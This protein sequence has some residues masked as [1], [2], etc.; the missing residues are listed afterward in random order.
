MALRP[1]QV[2]IILG[3]FAPGIRQG[4]VSMGRGNGKTALAAMLACFGLFEGT[5]GAQVLTVASDERQARHVWNAARRMI[6]LNDELSAQVQVFQD[7]IYAPHTDSILAPLPAEPDALQG[8]D[9]TF[10][11]VDELH[12]VNEPTYDAMNLASGKRAQSLVLAISTAAGDKD[13]VMY[14][15]TEHGR[16]ADDPAFYFVEFAAPDGCALDDEGAWGDANPALGDFLSIDA[17]RATLRTTREDVFR[18]YRLNQWVGTVGSWLPWGLWD[19]R[20]TER[21]VSHDERVALFFDGSASGDSTALVGCTLDGFVFLVDLWE[22]P[23]DRGWRVPRAQVDRTIDECFDRYDVV[24][25]ACDPWGWRSEIEAWA[26]RHKRVIEWPTNIVTR[27]APATDRFYA[28]VVDGDV[29]H[30]GDARMSA[31]MGH[32]IAD[33]TTHGDVIRK[34]RRTSPRKI[35]AAVGAIGAY[36]RAMFHAQKPTRKVYVV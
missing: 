25:L 34:D 30:D 35:D 19:S 29:S 14:R 32:C 9:P 4:L 36:D 16:M 23:G 22:N 13:G 1:W 12:V 8:F 5:E 7:R 10:C 27:M 26:E 6:A 2:E 11:I 21:Q 31:H 18:R 28:A 17:L 24:E 33:S 20:A 15:L 3:L